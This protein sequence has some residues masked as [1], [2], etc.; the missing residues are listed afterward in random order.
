[1]LC[2]IEKAR[3]M[4]L[5]RKAPLINIVYKQIFNV[6]ALRLALR[7]DA[8]GIEGLYKISW[9]ELTFP[10]IHAKESIAEYQLAIIVHFFLFWCRSVGGQIEVLPIYAAL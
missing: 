7:V 4:Y 5:A 3:V 9:Q 1:M 6:W 8:N 10:Q 2:K